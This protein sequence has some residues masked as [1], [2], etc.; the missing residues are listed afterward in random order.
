MLI[1]LCI[2]VYTVSRKKR[3]TLSD[4]IRKRMPSRKCRVGCEFAVSTGDPLV[5]YSRAFF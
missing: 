5:V 3:K 4:R 2:F 1:Y